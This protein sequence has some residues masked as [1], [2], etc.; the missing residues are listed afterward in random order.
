MWKT[1][2]Y[3]NLVRTDLEEKFK[4]LEEVIAHGKQKKIVPQ[5][6][7][8]EGD[9]QIFCV[10]CG[11]LASYKTIFKHI[12]KCYR[13]VEQEMSYGSA[14][15]TKVEGSKRLFCDHYNPTTSTI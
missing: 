12:D 1:V 8:D 14:L 9:E 5:P 3:P 15:E 2:F 7:E 10:V 11:H 6:Q 13:R 4:K